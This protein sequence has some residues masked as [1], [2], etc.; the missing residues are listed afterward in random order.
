MEIFDQKRVFFIKVEKLW[1]V[2]L[3]G[4]F[5]PDYRSTVASAIS[6]FEAH[7]CLNTDELPLFLYRNR[8]GLTNCYVRLSKCSMLEMFVLNGLVSQKFSQGVV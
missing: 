5:G 2:R 4:L 8:N 1:S 3:D 7:H 6:G